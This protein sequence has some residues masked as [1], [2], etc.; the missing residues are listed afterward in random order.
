MC[1]SPKIKMPKQDPAKIQA[2]T[3]A[4][5]AEQVQGVNFGAGSDEDETDTKDTESTSKQGKK[6]GKSGL[7][8]ELTQNSGA[9]R[10]SVKSRMK[11]K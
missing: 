4:P 3:P 6:S 10:V 7:R 11:S 5:L 1:F 9:K 2:P 8:V